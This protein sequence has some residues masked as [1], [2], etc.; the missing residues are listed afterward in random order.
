MHRYALALAA[1][2]AATAGAIAGAT[3]GATAGPIQVEGFTHALKF[4][5]LGDNTRLMLECASGCGCGVGRVSKWVGGAL[6]GWARKQAA[7]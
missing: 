4:L 1:M 7:E 6:S 5:T 2:P 3:A